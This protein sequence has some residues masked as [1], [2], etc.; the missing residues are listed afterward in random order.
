M[1][2]FKPGSPLQNIQ[3]NLTGIS[4]IMYYSGAGEADR[5]EDELK[6]TEEDI[7]GFVKRRKA[8][9]KKQK[10]AGSLSIV[11]NI[12]EES[13]SP[14]LSLDYNEK[15]PIFPGIYKQSTTAIKDKLIAEK[16]DIAQQ[17]E[18]YKAALSNKP[19]P[20][21]GIMSPR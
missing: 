1:V 14:R 16:L 13:Y 7:K 15:L 18:D 6:L 5:T 12:L 2:E 19:S 3:K 21:L 10:D 9:I 8:A 11:K 4:D 17:K 20:N